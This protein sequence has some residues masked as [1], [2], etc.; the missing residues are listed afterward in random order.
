LDYDAVVSVSGDGMIHEILNGFAEHKNPKKALSIPI[1]PVPTGS[2]NGLAINILGRDVSD[3]YTL[4]NC[5]A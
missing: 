4:L 2:G 5:P 3:H 1:A